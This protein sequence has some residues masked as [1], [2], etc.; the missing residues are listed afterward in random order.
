MSTMNA[1]YLLVISIATLATGCSETHAKNQEGGETHF[2]MECGEDDSCP[3]DLECVCGVCT[4]TCTAQADCAPLGEAAT[5]LPFERAS[6]LCEGEQSPERTCDVGC[7]ETEQCAALGDGFE[8]VAERCR[9][10]GIATQLVDAADAGSDAAVDASVECTEETCGSVSDPLVMLIVDTSGSMER[11][12]NCTCTS[13][14]CNECLPR[15]GA[16]GSDKNR[17]ASV[18]EALTGTFDDFSCER[19]AREEFTGEYDEKYAVPYHEPRGRQRDDGVLQAFANRVRFGLATFDSVDSYDRAVQ[20]GPE[21]FDFDRAAGRDG[22]WSYP[23]AIDM[24]QL[25]QR[26]DGTRVGFYRYPGC[27]HAYVMNTGIRSRDAE[28]GAL[29]VDMGNSPRADTVEALRASLLATRP[30]GGTPIAASLD[31]VRALFERDPEMEPERRM[32]RHPRHVVL[33]TDGRPNDDYRSANCDCNEPDS[34]KNCVHYLLPTENAGDMNCPYPRIEAAA[35]ILRCGES[36]AC[37]GG[38]VDAVHAIG[39]AVADD[40]VATRR[41]NEIAQN[42]GGTAVFTNTTEELRIALTRV[43]EEILSA[44]QTQPQLGSS[45]EVRGLVYGDGAHWPSTC[46]TCECVGGLIE[47]TG[48]DDCARCE[49]DWDCSDGKYCG[50]GYCRAPVTTEC[51]APLNYDAVC[52]VDG[53]TYD[54]PCTA[55][56][57]ILHYGACEQRSCSWITATIPDGDPAPSASWCSECTCVDGE[58]LCD[59]ANCG[60]ACTAN[61][62]CADDELCVLRVDQCVASETEDEDTTGSCVRIPTQCP[63]SHADERL[64]CACD[65]QR[66]TA[67]ELL[68]NRQ[69]KAT[70]CA[71]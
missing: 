20:R 18:L 26:S 14:G 53:K 40:P 58:I 48:S 71:D 47:C 55:A 33:I 63:A 12:T 16:D 7:T 64:Y 38:V 66:Y 32:P 57:E 2:L 17:W 46:G 59:D 4:D 62:P 36:E 3:N 5:C 31:D 19:H 70:T 52:G 42:G 23:P 51:D 54:S 68:K 28:S 56:V 13:A 44:P 30:Y 21:E 65:G 45:C 61:T 1:L 15:C 34:G 50:D 8:C 22:Q 35:R 24:N 9:P 6:A 11:Q 39:F 29:F 43:M 37:T 27:P 67:C 60:P 69:N 25:E 10:A 49:R 41:V